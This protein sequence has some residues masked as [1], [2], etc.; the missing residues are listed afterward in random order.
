MEKI[1]IGLIGAGWIGGVHCECYKRIEAMFGLKRGTINLYMVADIDEK[2]ANDAFDRYGFEKVTNNW[3]D[4]ITD[5]NINAVDICVG[6]SMHYEIAMMAAKYGKNIFCE[7]P[8]AMNIHQS[9]EMVNEVQKNNV[10]NMINFN[11]RKVPAIAFLKEMIESGQLGKI[12][13]LRAFF[14]QDFAVNP[15]MP[16]SWRF[17]KEIS[18]GGVIITLG[19]HVLDIARFLIGDI[20]SLVAD[21][22]TCIKERP[23]SK[24]SKELAVVDVDDLSVG[25]VKFKNGCIGVLESCWVIHGRKHFFEIEVYGSKGSVLFVSERLNELNICEANQPEK[26]MGFKN[27]LIGHEHPYGDIFNIKTGMGI[28]IKESFVIQ[29]YDFI[30]SILNNKDSSPNFYDGYQV[31]KISDAFQDSIKNSTWIKL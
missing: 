20:D 23:I 31:Q 28:G 7:K 9:E 4:V 3:K 24:D 17:K 2:I 5:E 26:I 10:K 22:S 14:A 16:M 25:L 30:N 8:L 18:G 15:G 12:N 27:V 1:N 11:Y 6:N 21:S 19:S 13:N 29:L